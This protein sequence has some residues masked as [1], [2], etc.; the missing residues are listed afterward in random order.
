MV[1][2]G[3]VSYRIR[4]CSSVVEHFLGKEEAIG[5]IPIMG[6]KSN[7]SVCDQAQFVFSAGSFGLLGRRYVFLV[8]NNAGYCSFGM[9]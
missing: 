1:L 2:S 4:P 8:K 3:D 5:S 6:F 7:G 9:R